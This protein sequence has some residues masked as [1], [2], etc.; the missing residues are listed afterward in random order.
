MFWVIVVLADPPTTHLQCRGWGKE[1]LQ[2]HVGVTCIP[3][4]AQKPNTE[5]FHLH[6][7]LWGRCFLIILNIL[8][9]QTQWVDA[10]E[11]DFFLIWHHHPLPSLRWIIQSSSVSFHSKISVHYISCVDSGVLGDGGQTL[12]HRSLTYSSWPP[13]PLTILLLG[14]LGR[15][16]L[17]GGRFIPNPF[18]KIN[19]F[20]PIPFLYYC[21][22]NYHL[23]KNSCLWSCH[24]LQMCAGQKSCLWHTLTVLR[25]AHGGGEVEMEEIDS[26]KMCSTECAIIGRQKHLELIDWLIDGNLGTTQAASLWEYKMT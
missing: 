17:S 6:A 11:L 20:I 14:V 21:T 8:F 7:W 1:I 15:E 16:W 25:L 24:P 26:V 3:P 12:S 4:W 5:C 22:N 2:P 9:L 10:N 19:K 23:V 18:L 13:S